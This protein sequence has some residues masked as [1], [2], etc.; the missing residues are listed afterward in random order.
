MFAWSLRNTVVAVVPVREDLT[1]VTNAE[2]SFATAI[3]G[4]VVTDVVGRREM[5]L[6]A[7]LECEEECKPRCAAL[8]AFSRCLATRNVRSHLM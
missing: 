4:G 3:A 1:L 2:D 6:I 7:H 8:D 5:S